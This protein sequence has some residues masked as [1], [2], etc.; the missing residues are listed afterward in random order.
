MQKLLGNVIYK[1]IV[2]LSPFSE[3]LEIRIRKNQ[4]IMVITRTNS[5]FINI[6][7]NKSIIDS[8]IAAATKDSMYAYE[9]EL[10]NGY[11]NYT[12][13]VR[14]GLTGN[15]NITETNKISFREFYSLCIRIPHEIFKLDERLEIVINEFDSTLVISPPF[16]GK[17][18]LI[19]EM[20]R[21]L[22][23]RYNTLVIDEREEICGHNMEMKMGTQCDIISNIPK[24][25]VYG[26]IIRT[27]NPQ[28][29][30]CDELFGNDDIK[31]I[32]RIVNSGIMVLAT[33]HSLRL[34]DV[35]LALRKRFEWY[36]IL[37]SKP[38]SGSIKSIIRREN[39]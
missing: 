28:L 33:Y 25:K 35:P 18:T 22:S 32:N 19:R 1:E 27:M 20:T 39:V 5:H 36:I 6:T 16:G 8:V 34:E 3:I 13:G 23:N 37:N 15:C 17:T 11:I 9:K 31:A 7:A 30:V 12:N 24:S 4:P 21:L 14:I 10:T 38:K 26:N 2:K 29:V